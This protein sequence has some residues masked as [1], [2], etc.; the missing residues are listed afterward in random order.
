[1][2]CVADTHTLIWYFDHDK[3]L[4][5]NAE[6]VIDDPINEIVCPTIVLA[7]IFFLSNK[8]RIVKDFQG[9]MEELAADSRFIFSPLSKDVVVQMPPNLEMHD[10]IIVATSIILT[11]IS[12]D[13]VPILT[14][15]REIQLLPYI[16][17]IW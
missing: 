9:I 1:M 6:S 13:E 5:T 11:K 10:A 2:R 16:K 8:R 14:K 15:D 12:G 7:E 3:R 17:T 4:G